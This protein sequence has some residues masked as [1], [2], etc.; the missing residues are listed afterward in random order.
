VA[1]RAGFATLVVVR[2][3]RFIEG[4]RLSN[5]PATGFDSEDV[6]STIWLVQKHSEGYLQSKD[7]QTQDLFSILSLPL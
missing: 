3:L 7:L 4:V 1:S 2:H 6:V 5:F